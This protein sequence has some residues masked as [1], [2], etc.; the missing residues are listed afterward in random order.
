MRIIGLTGGIGSGKSTVT[1][2]LRGLGA[3]VV[4]ADEAARA[5][6]E[7]GQPALAEIRSA[8]GDRVTTV[9]GR[10]DRGALAQVVFDDEAARL[11]LN[12][13][14]HPRVRE[15]MAARIA[16]AGT[17]GVDTVFMDTPLLY[18]TGL[19][20]GVAETVVVWVPAEVQVERA[21]A[22]GMDED[23]VRARLAAQM[24]LEEKRRRAARVIDN[25]GPLEDTARQVA[26]L[27]HSLQ[28]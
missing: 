12:S 28:P 8:F 19:D 27:W 9:E 26:D 10:L 2:M 17:A 3:T 14:V 4:D 18:E 23:D 7:P 16:E 24:P 1:G 13:I 15:W 6:V 22:R 11:K 21:V 25:S 5:V 20:A